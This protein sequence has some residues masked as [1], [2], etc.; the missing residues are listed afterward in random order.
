MPYFSPC[1][2]K[3]YYRH[4]HTVSYPYFISMFMNSGFL[5]AKCAILCSCAFWMLHVLFLMFMVLLGTVWLAHHCK[6]PAKA[7]AFALSLFGHF[8]PHFKI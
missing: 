6:K 3:L 2:K 1:L 5:E 8:I 7:P 4:I